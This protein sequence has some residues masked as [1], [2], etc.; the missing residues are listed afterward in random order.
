MSPNSPAARM[1]SHDDL[2]VGNNC[3][4]AN[5]YPNNYERTW[6]FAATE[7]DTVFV[8]TIIYFRVSLNIDHVYKKGNI[9]TKGKFLSPS[10]LNEMKN[11]VKCYLD[12]DIRNMARILLGIGSSEPDL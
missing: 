5:N 2:S 3:S 11:Y 12:K 8:L 7:Q 1:Y 10:R 4:T 9:S 6:T